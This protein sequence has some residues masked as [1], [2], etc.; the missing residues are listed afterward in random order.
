MPAISRRGTW[1][2]VERGPCWP[3]RSTR[4]A[5]K[6]SAPL[7]RFWT[8]SIVPCG[9]ARRSRST[10]FQV[11]DRSCTFRGGQVPRHQSR[12]VRVD[13]TGQVTAMIG[14]PSDAAYPRMSPDGERV[15]LSMQSN[16]GRSIW[17]VDVA[18]GAA[19]RFTFGKTQYTFCWT[20]GGDRLTYHSSSQAGIAWKPLDGSGGEELL[21][22]AW[23][24]PISWSPDTTILDE[25]VSALDVSIQAQ[26]LNLLRDI[27]ERYD[28]ALLFISH[29]LAVVRH[30]CHRIAVMYMG[31]LVELADEHELFEHPLHP[32]T[33]GL[34]DAVLEPRFDPEAQEKSVPVRG[35]MPNPLSPP[36]GCAFRSRCPIEDEVCG[37]NPEL[38]AWRSAHWARCLLTSRRAP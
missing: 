33:S 34:L 12:L 14:Q 20:P 17:M 11:R 37:K 28:L 9:A 15:A 23:F 3:C 6:F 5:S 36:K 2:T 35:E 25:A 27:Q 32:Y 30:L 38:R 10:R 7:F 1:F 24:W 31:E 21:F 16:D 8:I 19:T 26:I 13:R 4:T 29:N 22:D 18:R